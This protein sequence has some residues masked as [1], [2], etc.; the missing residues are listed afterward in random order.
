ML[1]PVRGRAAGRPDGNRHAFAC[2]VLAGGDRRGGPP[3]LA[4][5]AGRVGRGHRPTGDRSV[6]DKHAHALPVAI[7]FWLVLRGR[8]ALACAAQQDLVPTGEPAD[9]ERGVRGL[10]GGLPLR[11]PRTGNRS[12]RRRARLRSHIGRP[13]PARPRHC[14]GLV[15][16][17]VDARRRR[18][19]V[20]HLR[21][22][23]DDRVG[24]RGGDPRVARA[25][26][27]RAAVQTRSRSPG[28]AS[29]SR[30]GSPSTL[31]SR[32]CSKRTLTRGVP[33]RAPPHSPIATALVGLC[34]FTWTP[35]DEGL[36][37]AA[38]ADLLA[39]QPWLRHG[40]YALGG[41]T[42]VYAGSLATRL[43]AGELGS[44][45]RAGRRPLERRR[46]VADRRRP[47]PG[48][49]TALGAS[50]AL[51]LADDVPETRR[52][53]ALVGVRHRCR[54][55]RSPLRSAW[56]FAHES[57]SSRRPWSLRRR[58]RC[59]R[60]AAALELLQRQAGGRSL[61][62]LAIGYAAI[63]VTLLRRR[64][65]LRIRARPARDRAG[66]SR[67]RSSFSS[68]TMSRPRA[69]R[70]PPQRWSCSYGSRSDSSGRHSPSS[71]SRSSTRSS[72][73]R[74]RATCS[75][76]SAS[77]APAS[78]PVLLVIAAGVETRSAEHP[79]ARP[80]HLAV[81]RPW[82]LYAATL[83]ILQ[84]RRG[85][86]QRQRRDRRSSGPH[87]RELPLGL[88]GLGLLYAGLKR[89]RRELQIGGFVLFGISLAKLFVYDLAFL[90]SIA[91]AFSFLA[92][93]GLISSPAS[94]PAP[95][96]RPRRR[97]ATAIV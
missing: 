55:P 7:A 49:L 13:V 90:S 42:A 27:R 34:T 73:R 80:F 67:R 83:A 46:R 94:L 56:S 75:S 51:V 82:G 19:R 18:R 45:P 77:P 91:R 17:R 14:V 61:L 72:W 88:V 26:H 38:L 23:A 81:R 57:S 78:P 8:P 29:R 63:G 53:R 69:G 79:A 54:W 2:L 84:A 60:P 59:S 24:S 1:V 40:T 65:R 50:V 95:R 41:A 43:A 58:A 66:P 86:G 87:R 33:P 89:G 4:R 92:V 39:A 97:R 3:Q 22:D 37:R 32:G 25:T 44:R 71:G 64:A 35:S 36:V 9:V 6:A 30:T 62:A 11:R 70:Q 5:S 76:P 21:P 28:S 15:G 47:T 20:T 74:R 12:A 48:S 10:V 52:G 93:G 68:G 85:P 96:G 16:D 31:R